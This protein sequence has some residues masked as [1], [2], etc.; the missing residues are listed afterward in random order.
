MF[1]RQNISIFGC[2]RSR[3][4]HLKRNRYIAGNSEI[5]KEG[6]ERKRAKEHY[7][8]AH[9]AQLSIRFRE[10]IAYN[11]YFCTRLGKFILFLL[12]IIIRLLYRVKSIIDERRYILRC[13]KHLIIAVI[14]FN[15][16]LCVALLRYRKTTGVYKYANVFRVLVDFLNYFFVP[17]YYYSDKKRALQILLCQKKEKRKII[18]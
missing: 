14:V 7:K 9:K 13:L 11:A 5:K 10:A 16:H 18:T 6:E 15:L 4:L 3:F 1:Q 8:E 12:C 2:A 17:L